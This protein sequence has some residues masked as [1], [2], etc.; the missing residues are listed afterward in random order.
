MKMI[1]MIGAVLGA[2]VVLGWGGV[3]GAAAEPGLVTREWKIDGVA[4]RVPTADASP[5]IER[6]S[7]VKGMP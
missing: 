6:V 7:R 5:K 2:M 4:L 1:R 3:R